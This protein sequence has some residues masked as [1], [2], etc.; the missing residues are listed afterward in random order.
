MIRG[1]GGTG[2]QDSIADLA[3][4]ERRDSNHH[5]GTNSMLENSSLKIKRSAVD[6]SL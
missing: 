4:S 6:P 3:G 5:G 1:I 2:E